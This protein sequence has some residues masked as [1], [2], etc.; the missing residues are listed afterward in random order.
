MYIYKYLFSKIFADSN[1]GEWKR[2]EMFNVVFSKACDF[3]F[4]IRI[5]DNTA[6]NFIVK[7]NIRTFCVPTQFS[8]C[9][10]L[11]IQFLRLFIFA[12]THRT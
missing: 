12:H 3:G 11:L 7:Y 8:F 2:N 6:S 1:I 5:F 10:N 4:G 9:K